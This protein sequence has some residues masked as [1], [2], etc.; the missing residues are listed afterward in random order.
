M[1]IEGRGPVFLEKLLATY[2]SQKKHTQAA[3][4]EHGDAVEISDLARSVPELARLAVALPEVREDKV[5]A[6]KQQLQEG[7]Y[8]VSLD[9]LVDGILKE[10]Q[11]CR[12]S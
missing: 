7:T 10:L 1:K 11:A 12:R 4:K 8:R 9:E 6:I 3:R 2:E 5:R